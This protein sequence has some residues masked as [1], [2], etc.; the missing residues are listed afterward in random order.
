MKSIETDVLVVGGGPGG[1][2]AARFAARGGA[3]TLLIEKKQAIGSPLRCAEGIAERWMEECDVQR[4]PGW[5]SCT[6]QAARIFAPNGASAVVT[7]EKG[8]ADV[9]L[10]VERA[11]FDKALARHAAE[12]G[13][14]ILLKTYATGVLLQEGRIG[15]ILGTS[16]GQAIEI[17]A[18][19]T[20]AADGYESQVARWSGLNTSLEPSDIVSAFQYRLSNIRNDARYCD[21]Y[22]GSCAPGGYIWS[23]PKGPGVANVGIGMPASQL[24]APGQ[25]KDYL[26]RWIA[27]HPAYAQGQALEMAA[28]GVSTNKPLP[29][30]VAAGLMLVGD[31]ARLVNPLTGGGIVNAC[32][33]GKLAG[34]T[35]ADAISHG[36]CSEL[37]LQK[38]ERAWRERM[39]KRFKRNWLA[40]NKLHKLNDDA[41]N[42]II[43]A[44]AE[45][46]P[47][48][49][50]LSLLTALVKKHPAL[51][52]DFMELLWT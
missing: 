27:A 5:I 23:F 13:A 51:V 31:A 45:A 48:A 15:G 16:M 39:E 44:L 32:I 40:K 24:R 37:F 1:A 9:G 34:E 50:P 8:G 17:H 12:A 14:R 38:Y 28:G 21:F 26:D 3:R 6:P 22:L 47:T 46:K 49:S 35:A 19:I 42:R 7:P 43:E 10:V 20:I 41:F 36:D 25:I 33:T 30:T 11:L 52:S 18:G 29:Q 2:M 4:D